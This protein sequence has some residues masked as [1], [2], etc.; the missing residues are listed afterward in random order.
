[1]EDEIRLLVVGALPARQHIAV[2]GGGAGVAV[3]RSAPS[4][5][6]GQRDV[7]FPSLVHAVSCRVVSCRVV[8]CRVMSCRVVSYRVVSCRVMSC[9]VVSIAPEK[10]SKARQGVAH[11]NTTHPECLVGMT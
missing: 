5:N 9:R 6:C 10:G 1:M 11:R 4:V 2:A 3:L 8:S 7:M